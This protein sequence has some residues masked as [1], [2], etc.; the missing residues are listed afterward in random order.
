MGLMGWLRR[1]CGEKGIELRWV[2]VEEEEE[3]GGGKEG[4]LF[5]WER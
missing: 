5:R 3:G 2:E 1:M 4:G